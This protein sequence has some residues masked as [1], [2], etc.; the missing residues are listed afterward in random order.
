MSWPVLAVV[1]YLLGSLPFGLWVAKARGIDITKVG[2]GNI[3]ATNVSRAL[4]IKAALVVFALDIL[5]GFVPAMLAR[6]WYDSHLLA[7][8]IGL[9]AVLGHSF[10][11]FL[12]FRGGKGIS[13]GLGAMLGGDPVRAAVA[14]GAFL[15]V[16]IPTRYVSLS[17]IVAGFAVATS[18]LLMDVEVGLKVLY[19][20]LALF[21]VYRHRANIERLRNGT[22]PKFGAKKARDDAPPDE[23]AAEEPDR[24]PLDEETEAKAQET[25]STEPEKHEAGK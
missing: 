9:L 8:S 13:T 16:M 20:A 7:V 15:I 14:L 12:K 10:S 23:S 25:E 22:E 18:A 24:Q 4:G 21:I 6:E 11:P 3:G 19:V 17:S 1:S 2:S 5:K